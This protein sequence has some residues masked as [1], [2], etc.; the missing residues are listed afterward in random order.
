MKTYQRST[1]R[2][3]W[4]Y[5]YIAAVLDA[6]NRLMPNTSN[7]HIAVR[8]P[9][10]LLKSW[11]T[12]EW[13]ERRIHQQQGP[14]W[15]CDPLYKY[16]QWEQSRQYRA[17]LPDCRSC[18]RVNALLQWLHYGIEWNKWRAAHQ[19]KQGYGHGAL[20]NASVIFVRTLH[21]CNTTYALPR[22][23]PTATVDQRPVLQQE[24]QQNS[25]KNNKHKRE[26]NKRSIGG[27]CYGST[28]KDLSFHGVGFFPYQAVP[29]IRL[30]PTAIVLRRRITRER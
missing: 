21:V 28:N 17:S 7:K 12:S 14:Q 8:T 4:P 19:W 16:V 27:R 3:A 20:E 2:S 30:F 23:Y 10:K 22:R 15:Q 24:R 26:V 1:V 13:T 18:S 6:I 25:T 5:A 9:E 29:L 11:P